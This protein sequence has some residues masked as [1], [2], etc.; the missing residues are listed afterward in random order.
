[1]IVNTGGT[2]KILVGH[3]A[4]QVGD[5]FVNLSLAEVAL[6][7]EKTK[8]QQTITGGVDASRNAPG[9]AMQGSKSFAAESRCAIPADRPKSM[10]D[11]ALGFVGIDRAQVIGRHNTLT[12]LLHIR[13]LQDAAKLGLPQQKGLDQGAFVVLEVGKHAQFFHRARCQVLRFIHHQ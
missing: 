9:K 5:D 1:M 6:L 11:I 3:F 12:Q 10:F 7:F 4:F 8:Q 13:T 2:V